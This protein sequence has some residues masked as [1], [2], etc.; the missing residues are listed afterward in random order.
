M[1]RSCKRTSS[2]LQILLPVADSEDQRTPPEKTRVGRRACASRGRTSRAA[3]AQEA[4]ELCRR[5]AAAGDAIQRTAATVA[6]AFCLAETRELTRSRACALNAWT[7]LD[8]I[9]LL[10]C[11]IAVCRCPKIVCWFGRELLVVGPLLAQLDYAEGAKL[12]GAY[13]VGNQPQSFDRGRPVGAPR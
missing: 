8:A 12:S 3:T 13:D 5:V 4:D 9:F 2:K 1:R 11:A 6:D 10:A 7:C